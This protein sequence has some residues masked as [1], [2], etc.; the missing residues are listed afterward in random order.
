MPNILVYPEN[1]V[2]FP[3]NSQI[4]TCQKHQKYMLFLCL[5][6]VFIINRAY[7]YKYLFV[8]MERFSFTAGFPLDHSSHKDEPGFCK[9]FVLRNK[10]VKY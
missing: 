8:L 7:I 9:T 6:G 2:N 3:V 10:D 5:H 1:V 4:Q